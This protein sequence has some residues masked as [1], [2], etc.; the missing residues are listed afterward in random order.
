MV[1]I[2]RGETHYAH[3]D[4]LYVISRCFIGRFEHQKLAEKKWDRKS[5]VIQAV[6]FWSLSW[7]SVNHP[8]GHKELARL[9]SL[10]AS[11]PEFFLVP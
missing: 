7:Q 3:L 4:D 5:H 2:V 1:Y 9:W 6:T 10:T 11:W 8:K